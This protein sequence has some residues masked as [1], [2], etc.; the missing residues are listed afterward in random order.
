M[1]P[2]PISVRADDE[3]THAI[4]ALRRRA[5]PIPTVSDV[6]RQAVMEKFVRDVRPEKGKRQSE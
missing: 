5:D 4:A 1:M 3:L 2:K 6:I